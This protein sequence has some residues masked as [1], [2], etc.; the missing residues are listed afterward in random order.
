MSFSNQSASVIL[1]LDR[2][3]VQPYNDRE[4]K[5]SFNMSK[6][7]IY[8]LTSFV[9]DMSIVVSHLVMGKSQEMVS[10][11][12]C[13]VVYVTLVVFIEGENYSFFFTLT[14]KSMI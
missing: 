11:E 4:E 1:D 10:K 12:I 6:C 5:K 8:Q 9:S 2:K 3:K 13:A 7:L 14:V